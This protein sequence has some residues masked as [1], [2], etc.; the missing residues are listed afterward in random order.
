MQRVFIESIN[1]NKITLSK[2]DSFHFEKVLRI[3]VNE[4]FEGIYD[5]K[6]FLCFAKSINPYIYE[7]K[8]EIFNYNEISNYINLFFVVSKGDKNE[9]VLQKATELGVKSITFLTS[10]YCMMKSFD[11]ENKIDRY[12]KIAKAATYQSRRMVVPEIKNK[13]SILDLNSSDLLDKN[14]FCYEVISGTTKEGFDEFIKLG[15][16]DSINVLVGSEGGISIKEAEHLIKLGFIPISL[17]K[18][19]L[20]AET[21]GISILST[22]S[23][24]LERL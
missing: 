15:K 8:K 2:D 13:K 19:I 7:I 4:E 18:R 22:L 17:G 9:L 10:E 14:F 12:L 16:N 21:S 24:F 3:K 1:Q 23:F 5:G 6:L 20:R 11:L